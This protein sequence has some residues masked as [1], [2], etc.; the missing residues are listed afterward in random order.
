VFTIRA[1]S[2]ASGVIEVISASYGRAQNRSGLPTV[3]PHNSIS[4]TSC[5][6]PQSL[7]VVTRLCHGK[8]RCT[9][10]ASDKE[11]GDPCAGVPH[12]PDI[13]PHVLGTNV[14]THCR[15]AG[16]YKYLAVR[17]VCAAG[18]PLPPAPPRA[19]CYGKC[20]LYF[21]AFDYPGRGEVLADWESTVHAQVWNAMTPI[22]PALGNT[23]ACIERTAF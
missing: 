17:Y 15:R 16:T 6:A 14:L 21:E 13:T 8:P 2:C 11:F 18:P 4:N 23:S 3:C 20:G 1:I 19:D 12:S 5:H 9:L 22:V 10:L 7:G